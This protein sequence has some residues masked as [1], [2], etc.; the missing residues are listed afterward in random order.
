MGQCSVRYK[1][2]GHPYSAY[3]YQMA[4]S[5]GLRQMKDSTGFTKRRVS[6]CLR[7]IYPEER[8]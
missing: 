2:V 6:K 8:Y 4:R 5:I 7:R 1:Y 3:M